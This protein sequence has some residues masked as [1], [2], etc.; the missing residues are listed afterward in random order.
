MEGL[1]LR[2]DVSVTEF[3][4]IAPFSQSN[5]S[6]PTQGAVATLLRRVAESITELGE[7]DVQDVVFH[8][9]LDDE[10]DAWPS[11]TVYFSHQRSRPDNR[12]S[13]GARQHHRFCGVSSSRGRLNEM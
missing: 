6:R 9:E 10:G 3:S 7:V 4:T 2:D 12:P 5:P 8:A 11:V 13:S 1:L